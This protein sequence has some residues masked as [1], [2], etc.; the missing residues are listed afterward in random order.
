MEEAYKKAAEMEL[1]D[2]KEFLVNSIYENAD[3]L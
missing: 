3:F 2:A 1:P